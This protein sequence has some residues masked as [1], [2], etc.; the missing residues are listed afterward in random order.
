VAAEN[1]EPQTHLAAFVT[2][3]GSD[4]KITVYYQNAKGQMMEDV[5]DAMAGDW[6]TDAT[7]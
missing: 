5:Y 6:Q 1:V 7:G 2:G 4:L 3:V